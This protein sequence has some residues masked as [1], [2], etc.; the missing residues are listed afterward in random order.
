[1]QVSRLIFVFLFSG[2]VHTDTGI[3]MPF[4]WIFAFMKAQ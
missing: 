4:G 3:F 2:R 1:L